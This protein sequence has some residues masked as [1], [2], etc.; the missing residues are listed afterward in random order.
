MLS[1]VFH[2]TIVQKQPEIK[3]PVWPTP[4]VQIV[5]DKFH[6]M[7][8]LADALDQVRHS[9]YKRVNEKERRFIKGQRPEESF[10]QSLKVVCC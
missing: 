1:V 9:E 6:I 8:H 5:Y 10:F 4:N 7:K 2:R 3:N